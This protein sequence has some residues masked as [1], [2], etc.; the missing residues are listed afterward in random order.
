MTTMRDIAKR[1]KVSAS[2]VSRV[3]NHDETLS[4]SPETKQKIFE[5]AEQLNYRTLKSRRLQSGIL[6][7]EV[8]STD[9]MSLGMIVLQSIKEEVNDPYW[10]SIRQGVEKECSKLGIASLKLM[11]L[12]N[13]S[14]IQEE[15]RNLNGVIIIGRIDHHVLQT[16][17][18]YNPNIVLINQDSHE[19]QYDSIIFDYDKAA[20]LAMDHLLENGYKRV[21]YIGGTEL[22]S[23]EEAD[24]LKRIYVPDMRK[25]VYERKMAEQN[26]YDPNLVFIKEYSIQSGYELM[27]KA[28][29]KGSI[30][31]A[32]F[33]ASDSMAIG[34]LRAL[35]EADIAVP[36][37]VVIV[38]FNDIEM[39]KFTSPPLTTVK[40]PTEEMGRLG[41]R[42]IVDRL[43]GRD[44][45]IKMI[46]PVTLVVRE[47]S[48][49]NDKTLSDKR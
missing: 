6:K 25:I 39:A 11:R 15:L 2:T 14:R 48:V 34:A 4:V 9:Q 43:K 49:I 22:I 41:V 16:I 24:G 28:I 35:Q 12:Q 27:K 10:L 40:I 21:G 46:V 32:F 42:V 33:I 23:I 17:R 8:F 29:E 13:T 20:C 44:M 18:S 36:D 3:L 31:E 47:S 26:T 5:M 30:P 1:V 19:D 38:S 7:E 45:P 37:D